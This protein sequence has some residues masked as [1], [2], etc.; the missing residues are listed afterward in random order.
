M[1]KGAREVH[2]LVDPV[3][4]LIVQPLVDA[5]VLAVVVREWGLVVILGLLVFFIFRFVLLESGGRYFEVEG[6]VD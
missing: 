4:L 6:P 5:A 1:Q 2:G 3:E